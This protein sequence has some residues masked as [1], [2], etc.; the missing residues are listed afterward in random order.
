M[1]WRGSPNALPRWRA[2]SRWTRGLLSL[3]FLAG[4]VW[5][6]ILAVVVGALTGWGAAGCIL[7][8]DGIA[9]FA[10]GPV[11]SALAGLGSARLVLLPVLGGLLAGPLIYRVAREARGHSVPL[12]MMALVRRKGRVLKRVASVDLAAALLTIGFGGAAGRVG[13]LVQ[14][15]SAFGSATGLLANLASSRVR[16]LVACGA[17]GGVAA[18]FD[19]PMAGAVFSL[20]VVVGRVRSDLPL[21]LLTAWIS[22]LAARQIVGNA[23][24]FSVPAQD[25]VGAA[26]LPLFVLM[27]GLIGWVAVLHV[28]ALYR[29][30]DLFGA[31][32]F[33]EDLKPAVGGLLVGLVLW[34]FPDV[35]GAGFEAAESALGGAVSGELL[36]ALFAAAFVANCATLGSGG[37]G[38]VFGPALYLGVMLGGACG[39]LAQAVLPGST[40]GSG[41]HALAGAAAFFGA[42]ARAPVTSILLLLELTRDYR[43][44]A[45]L[46]AAVAGSVYVSRRLSRFSIHTLRLHREGVEEAE[47]AVH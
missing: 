40:A 15:G 28:R 12:V 30:E 29:T 9:A 11:A 34:R 24:A 42:S 45:P 17:A 39:S 2:L 13:P 4:Q 26:E 21:V 22:S 32:R 37:S 35:Y 31:W 18:V 19:A 25:P 3:P 46:L 16:T 14:M 1:S 20:E 23:P 10:R 5:F 43:I 27:G 38:G 36:A 47:R 41:A 33:P 6:V 8:L 44:L 7:L